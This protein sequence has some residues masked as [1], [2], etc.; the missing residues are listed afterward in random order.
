[1]DTSLVLPQTAA[2]AAA[3]ALAL[4]WF[5]GLR[6]WFDKQDS[7]TQR[8]VSLLIGLAIAAL[9][10]LVANKG[11]TP[12]SWTDLLSLF[13]SLCLLVIAAVGSMQATKAASDRTLGATTESKLT[14]EVTKV[15]GN[16]TTTVKGPSA[17]MPEATANVS[18]ATGVLPN[19]GAG[20]NV[21]DGRGG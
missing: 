16:T 4:D 11:Y 9:M 5:P 17:A 15:E 10:F 7:D 2:I 12:T 1:M 8:T 19:S 21:T 18:D 14:T 20:T 13:A 6:T 3:F